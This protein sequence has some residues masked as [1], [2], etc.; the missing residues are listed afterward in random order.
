MEWFAKLIHEA[1]DYNYG[2]S[3]HSDEKHGSIIRMQYTRNLIIMH[4][5]AANFVKCP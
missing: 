2:R 3:C 5:N 4:D 1:D